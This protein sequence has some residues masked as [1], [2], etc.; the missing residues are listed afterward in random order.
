MLSLSSQSSALVKQ[1]TIACINLHI[2]FNINLW[3]TGFPIPLC[4]SQRY[5]PDAVLLT[6]GKFKTLPWCSTLLLLPSSS[7]LVQVM[8]GVGLPDASQNSLLLEPSR[9]V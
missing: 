6:F 8:F 9:T 2:T 7:T 3:L 1:E 4:A 5:T